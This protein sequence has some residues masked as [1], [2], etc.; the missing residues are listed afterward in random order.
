MSSIGEIVFGGSLWIALPI[1]FAAG[2]FAFLSPCIIPLVPGYIAYIS[3][4]SLTANPSKPER[5]QIL[6]GVFGFVAGFGLVFISLSVLFG[7]LGL[8]LTPWLDLT[9]RIAGLLLILMGIVF[10]GGFTGLQR[11]FLNPWR[12]RTGIIGAPFLGIVFAL[13]WVPCVGPTLV[14]VQALAFGS[15]DP[16]RATVLG[17]AYW[18]GLAIPFVLVAIFLGRM[19]PALGWLKKHVRIINIAGGILLTLL[20]VLMFT[21]VWRNFVSWLGVIIGDFLPAL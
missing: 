13:G 4:F 21:G 16:L 17:V 11:E 12:T 10:A 20:G 3:G 1:A 2:L 18:L 6:L 7:S 5:R 14:A 9:M 15:A 8:L 19:V